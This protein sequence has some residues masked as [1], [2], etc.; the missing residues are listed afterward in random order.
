MTRKKYETAFAEEDFES[1]TATIPLSLL[2]ELHRLGASRR[3]LKRPYTISALLR[4][5]A[6]LLLGLENKNGKSDRRAE[7]TRRSKN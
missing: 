1:I 5:G 4:E 2:S 6:V 7:T 3:A